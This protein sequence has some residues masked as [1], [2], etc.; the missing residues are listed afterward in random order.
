MRC[1]TTGRAFHIFT[2]AILL[3][4]LACEGA[5]DRAALDLVVAEVD[6]VVSLESE[7]LAAPTDVAVDGA[8]RVYVLD[9][10]FAG[11]L[12]LTGPDV[13]PVLY[14][15]EGEGPG[16]LKGP[17]ALSVSDDTIRIV[18]LGNG[19]VQVLGADGTYARSYPLPAAFPGNISLSPVGLMA[20]P[21]Q[22]FREDSL[23]LIFD[24]DGAPTRRAGEP[25]VPPHDMWDM[26]AISSAIERGHVPSSLRN[27]S[28]PVIEDDG[29]LW[30]ILNAEGVV[31]RYDN[32]GNVLWSLTLESPELSAI[33]ESFFIRNREMGG[34]GFSPL[35]YVSDA[36][37]VDGELWLLLNTPEE[38]PVVIL[39][40][41]GDGSL[42]RRIR[43]PHVYDAGDLAVDLSRNRL[44][45][46]VPS[47]ASLIAASLPG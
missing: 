40:V 9:Y 47:N 21:T 6:T 42:S 17:V 39:A 20:V 28:L 24:A 27:M 23:I 35:S 30:L 43:L 13:S 22:G 46:T 44:Y 26:T 11:V 1:P 31:R 18:E 12:V 5:V 37:V 14:G 41:T 16:E 25:V 10:Q 38:S 8:G 29:S 45:L 34:I 36:V 19:R 2:F 15:S 3:P 7:L 33:R 4:A 32:E